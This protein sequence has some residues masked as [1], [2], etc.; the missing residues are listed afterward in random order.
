MKRQYVSLALAVL[1]LAVCCFAA[2]HYVSRSTEQLLA[3]TQPLLQA[4]E[5]Q[6]WPSAQTAY[7]DLENGWQN[8]AKIWQ[9]II[10][11]EDLRDIEVA[12]VDLKVM[13]AEQ[14]REQ[15]IKE[16]TE[17]I[18]YLGHVLENESLRLQNIL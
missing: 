8:C 7:E 15:S 16:L 12:L 9:M 5:N 11:H 3:M 1:L 6:D 13:L 17:L 18:F 2:L 14:S 10:N 4:V